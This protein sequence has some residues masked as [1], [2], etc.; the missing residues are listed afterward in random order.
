MDNKHNSLNLVAKICSD[1]CPW[2]LS[3]PRSSQTVR[4]QTVRFSEQIM[5]ADKYPSIFLRQIKAIVYF[6]KP[7]IWFQKQRKT[8]TEKLT[9]NGPRIGQISA[10]TV[11]M[12]ED[13][14]KVFY[15]KMQRFVKS[16]YM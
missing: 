11:K 14:K 3:V 12:K 2:T 13:V 16:S 15:H 7:S 8:A 5:S 1:I 9:D 10:M 6:Y 4:S